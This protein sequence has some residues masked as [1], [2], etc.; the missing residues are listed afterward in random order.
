[1]CRVN[2]KFQFEDCLV[3]YG[4]G[5]PRKRKCLR[6]ASS[7]TMAK[8][9]GIIAAF[10]KKEPEFSVS[11]I[12]YFFHKRTNTS[13]PPQ[14]P[15]LP[16]QTL[17]SVD[18]VRD[19]DVDSDHI[20]ESIPAASPVSRPHSI[21]SAPTVPNNAKAS[22]VHTPSSIPSQQQ[23]STITTASASTAQQST[24]PTAPPIESTNNVRQLD[25]ASRYSGSDYDP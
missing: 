6:K 13:L 22:N 16:P 5:I 4:V 11:V 18:L 20:Q 3:F 17:D 14:P 12:Y 7:S 1:M 9:H 15:T 19:V 10:F 8:F 2:I 23:P 24:T 25:S 21:V